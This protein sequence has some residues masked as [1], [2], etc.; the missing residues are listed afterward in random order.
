MS[1]RLSHPSGVQ[2]LFGSPRIIFWAM[3]AA[4]VLTLPSLFTGMVGDDYFIRA[5]VLQNTG[6][7][8]VPRSPINAFTFT[9]GDPGD[10]KQGIETGLYP[11]WTHPQRKMAFFRPLPALTH[12]I[13]FKLLSGSVPVMHVHS[14]LWYALLVFVAGLLYRRFLVP[15][16]V[17]GLATMFYA[18]DYSHAAGAAMLCSRNTVMVA[19]FSFLTLLAHDAWRRGGAKACSV[20]APIAFFASL[21]CGEAAIAAG[22]YL[23]AYALF[24][25]RGKPVTRVASLLP[26]VIAG[27]VWRVIYT[28]L[29]YGTAHI[30]LYIDPGKDM[31]RFAAN[32][33]QRLPVLLLGHFSLPPSDLWAFLP[34]WPARMYA[35][36][37]AAGIFF[38]A[39]VIWPLLRQDRTARFFA[40]GT[41]LAA[42]PFCA[43][44]P[45]NR[46]LFFTGLGSMG[47]ITGFLALVLEKPAWFVPYWRRPRALLAGI[48]VFS[49]TVVYPLL[50]APATLVNLV[51]QK[52]LTLAAKT[53][54]PHNY[55]CLS[56]QT[57]VVSVPYDQIL[58]YLPFIRA[59]DGEKP[60]L[61]TFLLSA[62][63]QPMEVEREDELTLV[64]RARSGML[65]GEWDQSF[66]DS[67]APLEKGYT[68]QLP[69]FSVTVT[70]LTDDGLPAEM[71]YVFNKPLE[72]RSLKWVTWSDNG[73][74]P[75]TLPDP[76]ETVRM[77]QLS[78]TWWR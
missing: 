17:A 5:A 4:C 26:Y 55:N 78:L 75:F 63:L 15:F 48:W 12:W 61:N 59:A 42:I 21:L 64:V 45:S 2:R 6:I 14:I 53:I 22:G 43:A 34:A 28:R 19:V 11:W 56:G 73:F 9:S 32:L 29:G 1:A 71:R 31:L 68:L 60:C 38:I 65:K 70:A 30:G 7:P 52:P 47:L 39:W 13:D 33:V 62:G 49:C 41:V 24:I 58:F 40:L 57:I 50:F 16:W 18:V 8:G 10:L 77:N 72:D 74:I 3:L 25:E 37:A 44:L 46:L 76:G 66:R 27:G 69:C 35:V 20:L 67:A 54:A 36:C 51:L 23:L